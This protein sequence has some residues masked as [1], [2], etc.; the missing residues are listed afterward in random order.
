MG[1]GLV[2][3]FAENL[4]IVTTSSYS[5]VANSHTLQFTTARTKYSQ[6]SVF[7]AVVAW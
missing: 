2:V 7:S 6:S 3:R 5:A 4:Q 1:F